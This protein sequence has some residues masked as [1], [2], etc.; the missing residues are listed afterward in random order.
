[1]GALVGLEV[2]YDI[3]STIR[4]ISM[5]DVRKS[6]SPLLTKSGHVVN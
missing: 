3:A 5:K 2:D 4:M 1:M 6:K